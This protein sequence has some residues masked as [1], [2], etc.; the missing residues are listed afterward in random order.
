V[1]PVLVAAV[2]VPCNR[3]FADADGDG[4]VDQLDFAVV[5]ACLTGN[6]PAEGV[7]DAVNCFCF[8]HDKDK[9]VDEL[10]FSDFEDC[11]TGPGVTWSQA[12]SPGCNP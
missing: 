2:F 3:P 1:D 6:A 9:D 5:Q 11:A 7:F 8:D 10:D 4:D 12:S